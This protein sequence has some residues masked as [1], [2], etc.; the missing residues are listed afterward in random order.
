MF[1]DDDL[2]GLKGAF[3]QTEN[4]WDFSESDSN[5][6]AVDPE[7]TGH[8]LKKPPTDD[9]LEVTAMGWEISTT[10]A[11]ALGNFALQS[12]KKKS[13]DLVNDDETAAIVDTSIEINDSIKGHP[14]SRS[15]LSQDLEGGL[16]KGLTAVLSSAEVEASSPNSLNRTN[17]TDFQSGA[18]SASAAPSTLPQSTVPSSICCQPSNSSESASQPSA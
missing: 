14:E 18:Q 10:A 5:I 4:T 17:E 13:E 6:E 2:E 12:E 3:G 8:D 16:R 9:Q 7:D 1:L 15:G 11:A